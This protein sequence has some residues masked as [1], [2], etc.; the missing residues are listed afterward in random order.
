[1]NGDTVSGQDNTCIVCLTAEITHAI[2]PCGHMAYCESCICILLLDGVCALCRG[3][4]DTIIKVR[5]KNDNAISLPPREESHENANRNIDEIVDNTLVRHDG[6]VFSE[7]GLFFLEKILSFIFSS[8]LLFLIP[9]VLAF[10]LIFLVPIAGLGLTPFGLVL[11]SPFTLTPVQS[12]SGEL[13]SYFCAP[14]AFDIDADYYHKRATEHKNTNNHQ[15]AINDLTA[16]I[17]LDGSN[18]THYTERGDVYVESGDLHDAIEDYTTAI[19][20]DGTKHWFYYNNLYH[21]RGMAYSQLQLH[22]NAAADFSK[23]IQFDP[24]ILTFYFRAKA[25]MKQEK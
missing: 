11:Q 6:H 13:N 3:R 1:M 14:A 7:A 2:V 25:Y 8:R 24:C 19:S 22:V 4:I 12:V 9:S 5:H 21:R 10:V 20:F 16:A 17:A 15:A 18:A 23:S